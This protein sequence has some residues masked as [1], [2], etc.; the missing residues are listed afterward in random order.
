MDNPIS[1][2]RHGIQERVTETRRAI[3]AELQH[4]GMAWGRLP[5]DIF[6]GDKLSLGG[7]RG[8]EPPKPPG[9]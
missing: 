4:F 8:A 9:R 2:I 1:G 5:I 3:D 7:G 6:G